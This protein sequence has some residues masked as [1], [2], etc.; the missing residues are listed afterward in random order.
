MP[1]LLGCVRLGEAARMS[2]PAVADRPLAAEDAA[3]APVLALTAIDDHG[4]V[5]VVL[6][7]LDHLVEELALEL[8]RDHAVDH[9]S[10]IVGRPC[11]GAR[12]G[13]CPGR[14]AR[15]ASASCSS[16]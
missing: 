14:C 4:H 10:R 2:P 5:G 1:L 6:V 13:S 8:A 16:P 3:L 7:V 12:P 11:A 15:R 9:L